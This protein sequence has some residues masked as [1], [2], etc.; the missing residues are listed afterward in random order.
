[1][2]IV[3]VE[4]GYAC[5]GEDIGN[6][7]SAKVEVHVPS[8]AHTNLLCTVYVVTCKSDCIHV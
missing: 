1:M 5:V 3:G 7:G 8:N 4:G 6:Y 2:V